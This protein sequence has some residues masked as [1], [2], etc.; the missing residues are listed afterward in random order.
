VCEVQ[1]VG[2]RCDESCT[3]N[4]P[5][6]QDVLKI[7]HGAEQ[8][9]DAYRD[10]RKASDGTELRL[11]HREDPLSRERSPIDE[12][13]ERDAHKD[14]AGGNGDPR[15]QVTCSAELERRYDD[16]GRDRLEQRG[17]RECVAAWEPP[18]SH[19]GMR[20]SRG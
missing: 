4:R 17:D 10:Q 12:A 6:A 16:K 1:A 11:E 15:R 3:R 2:Q 9:G 7:E 13:D 14:Q 8:Q 5:A 18:S 20:S 19:R